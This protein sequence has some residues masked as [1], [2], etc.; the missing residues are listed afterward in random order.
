MGHQETGCDGRDS[1]QQT[2]DFFYQEVGLQFKEE[3]VQ[4]YIWSITFYGAETWPLWKDQKY[5]ENFEMWCA[6]RWRMTVGQIV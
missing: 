1:I 6:G 5:L 3:T 2:E 4:C